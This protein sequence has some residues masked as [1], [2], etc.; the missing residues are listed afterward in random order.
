MIGA[1][2]SLVVMA[3]LVRYLTPKYHVLELIFLRNVINLLLMVP[4][5]AAA[6]LAA[7]KTS[8]LG[9]HAA[10]NGF[11]YAG[12][13]AWYFGV[14]LVPLAELAA[15]QFTMPIFTVVMAGLVLRES[16]GLHRALVIGAG[17]AGTLIIVR[18]GV[19][20]FGVGPFV[21]LAA[22]FFYSCAYIVTKQLSGTDSGNQV[23]FYMSLFIMIFSAIPAMF[24][25]RTPDL[26]DAALLIAMALTG[27]STHY[28][29]TRSMAAADASFVVP[30]DFL[31]LPLSIGFGLV[32]FAEPLEPWT[33]LGAAV[34]FAAAYYNTWRESRLGL[35]PTR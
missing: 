28:C 18:P 1:A 24:V 13:V 8:R 31:R 21:V 25:W 20:E 32:L 19:I 7:L 3:I 9:A 5:L 4:W 2:T 10:R 30:F 33:W 14:T 23:V 6:G 17:F 22:A 26:A 15:L 27:Y 35:N 29:V 34:I 16:I 11:L 12:N